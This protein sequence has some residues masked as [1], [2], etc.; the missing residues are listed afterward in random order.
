MYLCVCTKLYI[1]LYC[2]VYG[3]TCDYCGRTEF[4][5][6]DWTDWEIIDPE[7][8]EVYHPD[9]HFWRDLPELESV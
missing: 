6:Y 1:A 9:V 3:A 2:K 8:I 7:H 4:A 5:T